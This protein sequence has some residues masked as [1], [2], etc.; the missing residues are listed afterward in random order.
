MRTRLASEAGTSLAEVLVTVVIMGIAFATILGSMTTSI[1]AS[2]THRKM[3]TGETAIRSFA[4]SVKSAAYIP[5]PPAA[6][7]AT[8]PYTV[9]YTPPDDHPNLPGPDF[10]A[11]FQSAD[12]VA[13]AI[14]Y[15]D[16]V[17]KAW[18]TA[19]PSSDPGAQLLSL[20]V[21]T[22]DGRIKE[23][24]QIVKRKS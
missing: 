14:S 13:P 15:W 3:A 22:A 21:T 10:T 1:F 9:T 19:C 18:T 16:P 4:E 20:K 17:A 5:V 24:L 7:T 11:A 6:C 12:G 2:D 8:G 23:T